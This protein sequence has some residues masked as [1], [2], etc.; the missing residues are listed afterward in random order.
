[1]SSKWLAPNVVT[2]EPADPTRIDPKTLRAHGWSEVLVQ[3]FERNQFGSEH[4]RRY[5][6]RQAK[7]SDLRVSGTGESTKAV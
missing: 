3:F 6:L 7:D 5:E 2:F 1:M 4:L